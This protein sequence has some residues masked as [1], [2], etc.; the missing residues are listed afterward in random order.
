MEESCNED[1]MDYICERL[2]TME[3]ENKELVVEANLVVEVVNRGTNCLLL[4]ILT[5]K[6]YN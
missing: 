6:Y 3:L 1:T 5:S 2:K 4:K